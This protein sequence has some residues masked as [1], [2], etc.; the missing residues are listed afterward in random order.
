MKRIFVTLL[1][2]MSLFLFISASANAATISKAI[3]VNYQDIQLLVD[4]S[5]ITVQPDEEPLVYNGRTFVP[6]RLVA[7]ALNLS[8]EWLATEKIVMINSLSTSLDELDQKQIEIDNLKLQLSQ[9]ESEIEDLIDK[10]S[11]L[12]DEDN[13]QNRI[14][15]LENDLIYDYDYLQDVG[16]ED[17]SLDGDKNELYVYMDVDLGYYDYE[18]ESLRDGDI[19]DWLDDLVSDIQYELSEDTEIIGRITDTDSSDIL[20]KFYK[21]GDD[22]LEVA[23]YDEDYR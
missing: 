21:Y 11:S 4:G 6:I 2:S 15:D 16:I 8:V 10:I 17:I 9:K 22:S 20:V 19:E 18:W 7:E 23:Y 13:I 1:L 5:V 12:E 3:D 14:E